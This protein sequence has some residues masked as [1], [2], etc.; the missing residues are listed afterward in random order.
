MA[1]RYVL[2]RTADTQFMFVL[3][4]ANSETI[5]TSERYASKAAAEGGIASVRLNSPIDARYDRKTATNGAP[6][7]NLRAANGEVIGTSEQYTSNQGRENGIAS[8]KL[9]GPGAPVVDTT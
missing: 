5:L 4:A 3:K 1:A 9:N 8:V 7:F 2:S 6:M